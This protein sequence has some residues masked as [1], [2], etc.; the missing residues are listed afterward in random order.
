[1]TLLIFGAGGQVGRALLQRG[2]DAVIGVDHAACD[3]CDAAA[4]ERSMA[5][6]GLSAVVNCAAYTAVDR[7]ETERKRAFAVNANGA[8]NIAQAAATRGL[9]IIHLS[10]DYVYA[11]TREG[12]HVEGDPIAPLSVYGASKADGDV[13]VADAAPAHLLLRVSWVFGVH[14]SNFVKTMLRLGRERREL[15]V[16]D[17]QRGGPTEARDIADA[18]ITMAAAC[19]RPA[20]GAWGTYHFA[21]A[22][23]TTWCGFARAIFEHASDRAP[24]LVPISTQE[25]PSHARRP[26]NSLLDCSKIRDTFGIAQ[27]DWRVSLQRVVAELSEE[28]P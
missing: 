21:A 1:V 17:D 10:T 3:I 18:I 2:G 6:R 7:A 16:V 24:N 28:K 22:P 20:F 25:Y 11:G 9:P 12:A 13:A 14:G 23:A 8:R 5:A 15:R 26:L 19:R 27:P 4:V